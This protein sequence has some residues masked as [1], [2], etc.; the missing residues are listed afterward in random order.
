MLEHAALAAP[1]RG[2]LSPSAW[3]AWRLGLIEAMGAL[4]DP[5]AEPVLLA[6]FRARL[7]DPRLERAAAVAYAKLGTEPVAL[8]LIRAARG[9]A[10]NRRH[11]LRA[12]GHCRRQSSAAFL[13]QQL[14]GQPTEGD[15]EV[16]ARA[17][18]DVGSA[19]AWRTPIIA[20]SGEE[21]GVRRTAA[22]ALVAAYATQR[23]TVRQIIAKALLVVDHPDTMAIIRAE[24]RKAPPASRSTLDELRRRFARSPLRR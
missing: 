14:A 1:P 8:R 19:W 24:R 2:T 7:G 9:A 10:P 4:R 15:A 5:Q 20:A 13:A 3:L 11:A 6:L 12:L 16:L 18:G 21:Q 17:L 22:H 23:A